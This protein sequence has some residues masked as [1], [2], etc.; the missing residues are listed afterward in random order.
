[1]TC[2]ITLEANGTYTVTCKTN[3]ITCR[4]TNLTLSQA[5]KRC[6]IEQNEAKRYQVLEKSTWGMG[7][8]KW[9]SV[10]NGVV[11]PNGFPTIEEACHA[12]DD[13]SSVFK[14]RKIYRYT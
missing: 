9:Y 13:F 3:Y 5:N 14:G 4:E 12:M 1:M 7:K 6:W 10:E 8:L 11:T 2:K